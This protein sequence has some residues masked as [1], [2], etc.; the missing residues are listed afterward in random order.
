MELLESHFE[1]PSPSSG[2]AYADFEATCREREPIAKS[3]M[4]HYLG[5][6]QTSKALRIWLELR[7]RKLLVPEAGLY[8][9]QLRLR[10]NSI[11]QT[12]QLL[13]IGGV[14]PL[15]SCDIL[16]YSE[17]VSQRIHQISRMEDQE[18]LSIEDIIA[19]A[20]MLRN[21]DARKYLIRYISTCLSESDAGMT[22]LLNMVDGSVPDAM[23]EEGEEF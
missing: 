9:P 15:T 19:S 11:V 14:E 4:Y 5:S 2:H 3:L 16:Q 21:A 23:V 13:N 8:L 20:C 22:R 7:A 12:S 18:M 17:Y 10:E 6:N 1:L